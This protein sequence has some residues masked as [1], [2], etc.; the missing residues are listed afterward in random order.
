[1]GDATGARVEAGPV[2]G[3]GVKAVRSAVAEAGSWSVGGG[4]SGGGGGWRR[5]GA[6]TWFGGRGSGQNGQF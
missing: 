5:E 2:L 4:G 1:M 3:V 6:G